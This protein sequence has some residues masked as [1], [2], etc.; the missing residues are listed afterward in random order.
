MFISNYLHQKKRF[1]YS[2]YNPKV[3]LKLLQ[4]FDDIDLAEMPKEASIDDKTK[5]VYNQ[6]E[7]DIHHKSIDV[8]N[9]FLI[10]PKS[11]FDVS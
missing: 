6:K 10:V 7:T 1:S 11:Q 2:K 5:D 9:G 8:W 4:Q 3:L